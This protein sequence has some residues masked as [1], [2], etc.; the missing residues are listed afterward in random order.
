MLTLA[1]RL[2]TGLSFIL[3]GAHKA[4]IQGMVVQQEIV[5]PADCVFRSI[6]AALRQESVPL[7]LAPKAVLHEPDGG[8]F[9]DL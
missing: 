9:S 2:I 5:E 3:C 8:H 4:D 7:R 1:F 6:L